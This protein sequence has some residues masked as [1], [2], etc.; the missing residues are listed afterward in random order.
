M[1]D[2]PA[3]FTLEGSDRTSAPVHEDWWET[4]DHWPAW[5]IASLAPVYFIGTENAVG[6]AVKIGFSRKL[7]WRLDDL[8]RGNPHTLSVLALVE[9]NGPSESECHARFSEQRI[10]GEWFT[11]NE[12]LKRLIDRF[13]FTGD[14]NDY[15]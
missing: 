6:E 2:V 3:S 14:L 15:V 1:T 11:I 8:Q 10:H 4:V 9:Q 13:A 5:M 7:K 12:E